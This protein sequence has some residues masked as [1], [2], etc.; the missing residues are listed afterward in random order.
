MGAMMSRLE[1]CTTGEGAVVWT[2]LWRGD[3]NA[4]SALAGRG[5]D[6]VTV[7][8]LLAEE[9][10]PR[11]IHTGD[12][13]LVILRGVNATAG[14]M[15]EDMVSVRLWIDGSQVIS[16]QLRKLQ[17]VDELADAVTEG[18]GPTSPGEFLNV[19]ADTLTDRMQDAVDELDVA[20]DRLEETGTGAPPPQLRTDIA[21]IRPR[22]GMLRRF[23]APQRDALEVLVVE[24]FEWQSQ[25]QERRLAETVDRI[26]RLVEQLDEMHLRAAV[27]QESLSGFV[28]EKLNR[29]MVLLSVIA[30]I[31]MPLGFV[32]G[33]LGM[34]VAG[35]PFAG[36]GWAFGAVA[37]V[38]IAFGGFEYWLFRRLGL[39]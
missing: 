33:L 7:R 19:L 3:G 18:R 10:R 31:F 6:P 36:S 17:A 20:L 15:L 24:P 14:T 21:R 30:G 26:T 9:T 13:A 28:A 23:I 8:A 37:A 29:T 2:R 38:L 5:I 4:E 34:N 1:L 27:A 39:F 25:L 12:G 32:T 11:A 35:I 22:I 16:V